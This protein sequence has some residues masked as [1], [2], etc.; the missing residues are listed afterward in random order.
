MQDVCLIY[1]N[2]LTVGGIYKTFFEN[3]KARVP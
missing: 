2:S 1:F 3:D